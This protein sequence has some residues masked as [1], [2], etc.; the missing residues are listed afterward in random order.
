L[1]WGGVLWLTLGL[2]AYFAWQSF[3]VHRMAGTG[4]D[5]H[6][7]VYYV[8]LLRRGGRRLLYDFP[9]FL[10]RT[11][12]VD[13]QYFHWVLSWAGGPGML[14][15]LSRIL[16]P[17]FSAL[18]LAVFA[19][20]LASESAGSP[21]PWGANILLLAFTPQFQ[22]STNVRN[23]GLNT[24]GLGLLLFLLFS[25]ACYQAGQ[26]ASWAW[27]AAAAGL[28][29][30]IIG[31]NIFAFQSLLLFAAVFLALFRSPVMAGAG[32]AGLLL[33]TALHPRYAGHYFR[34]L[35]GFWS[36]YADTL[37]ERFILLR[38]PSLW[39]DWVREIP[40]KWREKRSR[41]AWYAYENSVAILV[42][43]QPLALCAGAAWAMLPGGATALD[44]FSGRMA[45][46]SLI[47]F[48]AT[49][50]RRTR[51]LGSPERYVEMA[52]PFATALGADFLYRVGGFALVAVCAAGQVALSNL[53]PYM[54]VFR[55]KKAAATDELQEFLRG[56][57]ARVE[58]D[59]G[60]RPVRFTSNNGEWGKYLLNADW[61]FVF[62]WP[63]VRE[64]GGI[65]IA[66]LMEDYPFIKTDAVERLVRRYGVNYCLI[67]RHAGGTLG[68][69][70][71]AAVLQESPRHVL[72]RVAPR[73]AA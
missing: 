41:A 17:L 55:K 71:E 6:F 56:V 14:A 23:Y 1:T 9:N 25:I 60:G 40:S 16:N 27:F 19:V 8:D 4:S 46:A 61:R 12:T 54:N 65:P 37:A 21:V 62:F 50:F 3:I 68:G 67:D 32:L 73:E 42:V 47:L 36:L 51:F 52:M 15:L 31:C 5:H 53:Q 39:G 69:G 43:F 35:L 57:R 63:T 28:A 13:P 29:W 24:R 59:A 70:L 72:Y 64:I 7:Y 34:Q 22:H 66:E 58:Q 33:F 45:A 30:L 44:L 48:L 26:A 11:P 38:R 10:N 2:A 49:S 18:S 20:F